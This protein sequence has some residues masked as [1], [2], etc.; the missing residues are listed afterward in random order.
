MH[1]LLDSQ[2]IVTMVYRN[3]MRFMLKVA[4]DYYHLFLLTGQRRYICPGRSSHCPSFIRRKC[5]SKRVNL[6]CFDVV[7]GIFVMKL[8]E[9][10]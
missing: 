9:K 5:E 1:F 2:E 7:Y 4:S 6:K 3:R 10:K 8:N